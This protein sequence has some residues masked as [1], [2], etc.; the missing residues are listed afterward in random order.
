MSSF[1]DEVHV[2]DAGVARLIDTSSGVSQAYREWEERPG[3]V[4]EVEGWVTAIL[5]ERG[6][7][8]PG[9]IREGNNIW[10]NTGR[11]FIAMLMSLSVGST[12]FRTDNLAY[13][14]V[15]IG[16]Q[17]EDPG[18]LQLI[19]PAAY[20]SGQFLASLDVPPT[21]PLSPSRTTVKYHRTFLENELTLTVASRV[22]VT[23]LGLFTDGVAAT[24][25]PGT[26]DRTLANATL[27]APV[28]YKAFEALGKT[29]SMQLDISWEIR[30]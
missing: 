5:R 16:S 28:A 21:F 2:R 26:R 4:I 17:T 24:Y 22:D 9:G 18:V 29:D 13:I 25:V 23:E 6:K 11:E 19:T 27:Q 20:S 7:I 8:V 3:S 14:G 30:F 12:K 10:T 15:G 1:R